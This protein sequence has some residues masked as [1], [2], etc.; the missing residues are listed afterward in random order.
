MDWRTSL[1][2]HNGNPATE[3]ARGRP[4]PG[5][6]LRCLRSVGHHLQAAHQ[7]VLQEERGEGFGQHVEAAH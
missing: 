5:H 3:R 7:L 2:Q 6:R 1:V 4:H